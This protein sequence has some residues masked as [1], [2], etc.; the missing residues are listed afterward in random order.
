MLPKRAV[1]HAALVNPNFRIRRA[2][3]DTNKKEYVTIQ[4]STNFWNQRD[5]SSTIMNSIDIY[6]S[7]DAT[8]S[9][10]SLET[11]FNN[12]SNYKKFEKE[13]LLH[14]TITIFYSIAE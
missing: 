1:V 7:G 3:E 2:I 10:D 8:L 14:L 4:I 6:I 9:G 5:Y 12:F 13:D 11:Q